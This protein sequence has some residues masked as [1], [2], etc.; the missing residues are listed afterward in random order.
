RAASSTSTSPKRSPTPRRS[1]SAR[2]PDLLRPPA[3]FGLIPDQVRAMGTEA[4]YA[5]TPGKLNDTRFFLVD[6]ANG[7]RRR[8]PPARAG[9]LGFALQHG[10]QS[11]PSSSRKML[12]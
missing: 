7:F 6:A 3:P 9:K 2:W 8:P 11:C 5:D 1:K 12:P 10:G 4:T